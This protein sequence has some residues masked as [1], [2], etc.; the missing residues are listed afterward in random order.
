M[1]V[2]FNPAAFNTGNAENPPIFTRE[3]NFRREMS[4]EWEKGLTRLRHSQ[5]LAVLLLAS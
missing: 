1:I 3:T 4:P 5:L 2:D